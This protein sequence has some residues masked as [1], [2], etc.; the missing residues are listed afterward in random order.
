MSDSGAT[1]VPSGEPLSPDLPDYFLE[2]DG[3]VIIEG[4]TAFDCRSFALSREDGYFQSGN[5]KQALSMLQQCEKGGFLEQGDLQELPET[6]DP[7]EAEQALPD[8]GGPSGAAFLLPAAG[9]LLVTSLVNL[10]MISR[11]S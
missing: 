10:K 7:S 5:Q 1:A 6:V 3:T 4:D 11:H 9:L 2:E 8:T